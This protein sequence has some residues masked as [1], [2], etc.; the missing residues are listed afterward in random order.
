MAICPS[1]NTTLALNSPKYRN[2]INCLTHNIPREY[3]FKQ[4]YFDSE[5]KVTFE[6]LIQNL[7][8]FYVDVIETLVFVGDQKI[9]EKA[10]ESILK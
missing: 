7:N 10:V 2:L 6:S 3:T 9:D 8:E 1:V 5:Q 4:I